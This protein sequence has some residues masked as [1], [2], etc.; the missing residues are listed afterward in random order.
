M[1]WTVRGSNSGWGEIF[2]TCPDRRCGPPSL[3]YSWYR[4]FPGGKAAGA[5]RWPPTPSSAEVKER[6]ELYLSSP[7]GPSWPLLGWT[8]PLPVPLHREFI[9]FSWGERNAKTVGQMGTPYT[10][11]Y[12]TLSSLRPERATSNINDKKYC[13]NRVLNMCCDHKVQ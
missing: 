8:L 3:L 11:T 13:L 7:S 2:C 6:V 9:L 1:G 12:A 4:V 5:W 10:H